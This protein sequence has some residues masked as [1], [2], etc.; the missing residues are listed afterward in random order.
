VRDEDGYVAYAGRLKDCIRRRGEMIAAFEIER[1]VNAHPGV[2]ESAAVG[3]ASELGDKDVKLC[4]V[5]RPEAGLT[6]REV[7]E[8]C[9]AELPSFMVPRWIELRDA[10]PRTATER[11]RK[12]ELVA[13]GV[14]GCWT[15]GR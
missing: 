11:V 4:V 3:V 7:W 9:R 15:A 6:A 2:L 5:A 14:E 13:E 8:Y 1:V 10:L 12:P